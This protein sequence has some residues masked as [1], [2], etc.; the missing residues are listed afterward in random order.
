MKFGW[1]VSLKVG[2]FCVNDG[3]GVQ[4]WMIINFEFW[5][6][7]ISERLIFQSVYKKTS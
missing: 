2:V 1:K 3:V 4:V 7:K 6:L 5:G